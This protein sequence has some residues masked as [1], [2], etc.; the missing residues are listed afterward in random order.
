MIAKLQGFNSLYSGVRTLQ[1][2][3]KEYCKFKYKLISI[4]SFAEVLICQTYLENLLNT[5]FEFIYM[6]I[7]SDRLQKYINMN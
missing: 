5:F 4:R 3:L 7:V 6:S 2:N 1:K